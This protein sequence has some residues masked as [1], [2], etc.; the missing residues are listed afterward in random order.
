MLIDHHGHTI[1]ALLQEKASSMVGA[2]WPEIIKAVAQVKT[3]LVD[4]KFAFVKNISFILSNTR[5]ITIQ[6]S[7]MGIGLCISQRWMNSRSS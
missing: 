5:R 3:I 1:M 6:V 4:Y 2:G 7:P